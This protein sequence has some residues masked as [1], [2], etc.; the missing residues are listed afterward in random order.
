[1]EQKKSKSVRVTTSKNASLSSGSAEQFTARLNDAA[2]GHA[3]V[4]NPDVTSQ[5]PLNEIPSLL[6]RIDVALSRAHGAHECLAN[7]LEPVLRTTSVGSGSVGEDEVEASSEIGRRLQQILYS[8]D[9]LGSN[10]HD[11]NL[12]VM[13]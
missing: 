10:L 7:H 9:S 12:N 13:L 4:P 11:T 8:I 5:V 1:M 6:S 3:V 2:Y